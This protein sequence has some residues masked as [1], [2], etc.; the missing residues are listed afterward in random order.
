MEGLIMEK[1]KMKMFI[2][3]IAV[4]L[5]FGMIPS[6]ASAVTIIWKAANVDI[7]LGLPATS[8]DFENPAAVGKAVSGYTILN[9]LDADYNEPNHPLYGDWTAAGPGTIDG[10]ISEIWM[11]NAGQQISATTTVASNVV[12]VHMIGDSNGGMADIWVDDMPY[13]FL[14]MGT[15]GLPQTALIIVK[16]LATTTHN[17]AV[18]DAGFGPL[19]RLGSEVRTFGAAALQPN[20]NV[21]WWPS[22]WFLDARIQLVY[23]NGW[24]GIPTGFWWGW[25]PYYYQGYWLRPWCGP[26]GWYEPY[27]WTWW[28]R[29]Y[30][31]YWP[32]YRFYRPWWHYWLWRGGWWFWGFTDYLQY[33]YSSWTPRVIY[34]WSWYWDPNG[35][36]GV[37]EMV[38][39][40]DESNPAGKRILPFAEP[41]IPGF[42]AGA[43]T[44]SV[45]GGGATGT[46][47]SLTFIPT[48]CLQTYYQGLPG[49]TA[50]DVNT[51]MDSDIVKELMNNDPCGQ[52][53]I[54]VQSALWTHPQPQIIIDTAEITVSPDQ[55]STIDV[56]PM[57][58]MT[59]RLMLSDPNYLVIDKEELIFDSDNY[60]TPQQVTISAINVNWN[61]EGFTSVLSIFSEGDPNVGFTVP[62]NIHYNQ[63]G[64]FGFLESD[65][66]R[67]CKVDFFDFASFANS[68]LTTT[69]PHEIS[70]YPW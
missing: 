70:P 8:I 25:W 69:D 24:I 45:N 21:K 65:F 53:Y 39:Q 60:S 35:Q 12:S 5:L 7:T 62:V 2:V 27:C 52:G 67:D 15:P 3:C 46:F 18:K 54:G 37:M 20:W 34:Y 36:G 64:G 26:V 40:A 49:V 23:T 58:P 44:F 55:N 63:C 6:P 61:Q 10:T 66:N 16:N 68:W 28:Y 51:F 4:G 41:N 33:Q 1:V 43:H 57:Y 59:V 13:A 19:S 29:P 14:D 30:W 42:E 9:W 47:S 56:S 48:S 32:W 50:D 22:F 31:D 11:Q 38:T 17:I